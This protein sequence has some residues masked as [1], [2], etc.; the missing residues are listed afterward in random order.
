MIRNTLY[1]Y[2]SNTLVITFTF[3]RIIFWD[4]GTHAPHKNHPVQLHKSV[5]FFIYNIMTHFLNTPGFWWSGGE[6]ALVFFI[7]PPPTKRKVR[8][9]GLKQ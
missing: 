2:S 9:R 5:G 1:E 3:Y 6:G 7:N 4:F 8:K